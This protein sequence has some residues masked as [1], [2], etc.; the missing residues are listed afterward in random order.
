VARAA[1]RIDSRRALH[2]KIRLPPAR[3]R[4]GARLLVANTE[5]SVIMDGEM[6]VVTID[7]I[8]DHE[9]IVFD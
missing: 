8:L 5:K 2:V 1:G 3:G 9:V 4:R 6:G 7:A